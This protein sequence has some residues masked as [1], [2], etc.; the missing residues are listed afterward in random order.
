MRKKKFGNC[1]NSICYNYQVIMTTMKK[2]S[3]QDRLNQVATLQRIWTKVRVARHRI[4][5]QK[6]TILS[7]YKHV[8]IDV[9][10]EI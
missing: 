6:D 5:K 3:D 4:Q 2:I 9:V 8:S 1:F 10:Y 7:F